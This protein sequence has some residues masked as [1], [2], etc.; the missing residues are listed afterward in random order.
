MFLSST[1]S[2][3]DSFYIASIIAAAILAVSFD[4]FKRKRLSSEDR[5]VIKK[6]LQ[7]LDVDDF[8]ENIYQQNAWYGYSLES[9]QK[10]TSFVKESERISN[11]IAQKKS[12]RSVEKIRT[13]LKEFNQLVIEKM[14]T[15]RTSYTLPRES[16][17][18][19]QSEATAI[20]LNE[21]TKKIF[22]EL[23]KFVFYIKKEHQL[24]F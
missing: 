20:V 8:Q 10:T 18:Y 16:D 23:E 11:F 4:Y 9:I 17:K 1:L 19:S 14:N 15:K 24:I 6:L 7:T 3:L 2:I 21:K 22:Q 12:R 5:E 13:L